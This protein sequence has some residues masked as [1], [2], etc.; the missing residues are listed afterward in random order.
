MI[1]VFTVRDTHANCN[2]PLYGRL[3]GSYP[4][5]KPSDRNMHNVKANITAC[6]FDFSDSAWKHISES[7]EWKP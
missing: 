2:N 6:R 3:C 1:R 7:G 5:G 4:F